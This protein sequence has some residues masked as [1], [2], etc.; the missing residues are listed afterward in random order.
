MQFDIERCCDIEPFV[1]TSYDRNG[2]TVLLM[3]CRNPQCENFG[4]TWEVTVEGD[5]AAAE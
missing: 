1:Q 2:A 4:N 5:D 3:Q